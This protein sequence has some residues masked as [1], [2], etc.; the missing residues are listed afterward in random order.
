MFV[1]DDFCCRC[2]ASNLHA[3]DTENDAIQTTSAFSGLIA[4]IPDLWLWF[5]VSVTSAPA[6]RNESLWKSLSSTVVTQW[7]TEMVYK[8]ISF[9]YYPKRHCKKV[10]GMLLKKRLKV[11][12]EYGCGSSSEDKSQR[13]IT[14][15]LGEQSISFLG[16]WTDSRELSQGCR[17]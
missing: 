9:I 3:W 2:S 1:Q 8:D 17:V 11:W 16:K 10:I 7:H 6:R 12:I 15:L 4:F 5:K 13:N 14:M